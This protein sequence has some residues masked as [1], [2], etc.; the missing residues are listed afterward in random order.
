[1]GVSPI[2]KPESKFYVLLR[3]RINSSHLEGRCPKDGGVF[4]TREIPLT[5]PRL[6]HLPLLRGRRI[7]CVFK[8][9][10]TWVNNPPPASS[11]AGFISSTPI[12]AQARRRLFKV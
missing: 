12:G 10:N 6:G 5:Q 11:R 1:L 4:N 8:K 3:N 9:K 2:G 7:F